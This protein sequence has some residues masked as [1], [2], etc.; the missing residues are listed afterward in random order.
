MGDSK[1]VVAEDPEIGVSGDADEVAEYLAPEVVEGLVSGVDTFKAERVA[2]F[3]VVFSEKELK[4]A[5]AVE[6]MAAKEVFIAAMELVALTKLGFDV[7]SVGFNMEEAEADVGDDLLA[8]R[9]DALV[10]GEATG[11]VELNAA[12]E[13]GHEA[14][15]VFLDKEGTGMTA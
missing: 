4:V 3:V 8:F 7:V 12:T 14:V 2:D 1:T 11:D 10:T 5:V 15:L 13:T 9:T 6:V